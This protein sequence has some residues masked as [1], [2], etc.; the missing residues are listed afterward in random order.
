MTHGHISPL[1]HST[2]KGTRISVLKSAKIGVNIREI[3]WSVKVEKKG[4]FFLSENTRKIVLGHPLT[5]L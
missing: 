4:V 3:R 2:L 1:T 5:Y